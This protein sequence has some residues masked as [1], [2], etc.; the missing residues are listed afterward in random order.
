[1]ER[2]EFITALGVLGLT[3]CGGEMAQE[4]TLQ[5]SPT[6]KGN[7]LHS[8]VPGYEERVWTPTMSFGGGS[9]GITYVAQSGNYTKIGRQVIAD[10]QIVLSSKGSSAGSAQVNGLPISS[11]AIG[12]SVVSIKWE[13]MTTALIN[14]TGWKLG[15]GTTIN[16]YGTAAATATLSPLANTDFSNDTRLY[17]SFTY[18]I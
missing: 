8:D 18:F 12:T 10:F 14:F 3:G 1:M 17:G 16:L 5:P 11:S 7:K 2:R 13:S 4:F 6:R 9:T 15:F